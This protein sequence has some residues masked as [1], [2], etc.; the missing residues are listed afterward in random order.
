LTLILGWL[1]PF[2]VAGVGIA[3]ISTGHHVGDGEAE[4]LFIASLFGAGAVFWVVRGWLPARWPDA[5]LAM[6]AVLITVPILAVEI[7]LAITLL[8]AGANWT[9]YGWIE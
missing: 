1:W 3:I 4:L 8:A 2:V 7:Y 9:G 6:V 5:L